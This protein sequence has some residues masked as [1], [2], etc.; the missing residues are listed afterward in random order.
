MKQ[1]IMFSPRPVNISQRVRNALTQPDICHRN[2]EFTE[3]LHDIKSLLKN[4]LCFGDEYEIV[5]LSGS[6]TLAIEIMMT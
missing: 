5:I 1:A 6:D 3:L 4:I 2:T